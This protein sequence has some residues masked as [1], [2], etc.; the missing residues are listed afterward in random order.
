VSATVD[1]PVDTTADT[2]AIGVFAGKSV[3]HDVD[4]GA[5]QALVDA[6]EART[7]FKHLAVAHAAGRRWIIVG[8]GTRDEFDAERARVA[9]AVAY[10]RAREL[11]TRELCWELPHRLDDRTAGEFVV[12]TLLAAYRF[13]AYKRSRDEDEAAAVALERLIIC[14]HEDRSGAVRWA[15]TVAQAQN[16]ARDLQ[17]TPA[18]DMTPSRLG[19]RALELAS[20]HEELTAE[21]VG[22]R[23]IVA[24]GMGAFA[25]VA[26][27]SDQEPALITLHYRP[28]DA[29]GPVLGLIGKG[30]T[31]DTGGL[32]IKQ[33][34]SM[35]KMKFDMSGAAAV[36]EATG[37]IAQLGLRVPVIAVVGATENMISGRAV[38]PGDIVTAMN[39]T[40]IEVNNTDAEGRMVLGDCLSHAI[41][42]GAERLVDLATLTGGVV[43]ALGSVYAGLM[44]ND[45]EWATA[46]LSAADA[47]GERLWRLPLHPDYAAMITGRYA[48]IVNATPE[49]KAH[50]I[51]GG[52]FLHRF[53]GSVPWAHLDIAG[54]AY[55]TGWPYAAQGGTGFGVRTLVELA[56][57]AA[58]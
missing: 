43:T 44:S 22:R 56:R 36:L 14:D 31:H 9:A 21:V 27:G 41:A 53:A 3:A 20:E 19:E 13:D 42:L 28:A 17:N 23:E 38:K 7:S 26:A 37:V 8:L 48:D 32:S 45:D 33:A 6:G 5:L 39:G 47:A 11:G 12:G 29:A 54:V 40:T 55:D 52:E 46:V 10:G 24:R 57:A 2:V 1:A 49:R 58:A 50:P 25:A 15:A 35:D 4:A 30:V 18:N 16:A 34:A 51:T